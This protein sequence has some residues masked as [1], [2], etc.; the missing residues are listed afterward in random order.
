[1]LKFFE[2][3]E[4]R[5]EK[6]GMPSNNDKLLW[7]KI[8]NFV[9][10]LRSLHIKSIYSTN[11]QRS[12]NNNLWN[13]CNVGRLH[14]SPARAADKNKAGKPISVNENIIYRNDVCREKTITPKLGN[15]FFGR[16]ENVNPGFEESILFGF[17]ELFESR[18]LVTLFYCCCVFHRAES[19]TYL[20]ETIPAFG[21]EIDSS[22]LFSNPHTAPN[23]QPDRGRLIPHKNFLTMKRFIAKM[24]SFIS[25][26]FPSWMRQ[27]LKLQ[28][29]SEIFRARDCWEGRR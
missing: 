8:F 27:E 12:Y 21:F 22:S 7:N 25:V 4:V 14:H 16:V 13:T 11:T 6:P 10:Q 2:I 26:W 9:A 5:D 19:L 3:N 28:A 23:L 18:Q 1:M 29:R 17:A 15:C 24:R 20:T